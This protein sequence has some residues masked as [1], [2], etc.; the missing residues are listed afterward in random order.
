M[1]RASAPHD[2]AK[3]GELQT[4]AGG[5]DYDHVRRA[6]YAPAGVM[7]SACYDMDYLNPGVS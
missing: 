2:S 5:D 4:D 7:D 1:A 6:A 3:R